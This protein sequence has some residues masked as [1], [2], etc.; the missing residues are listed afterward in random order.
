MTNQV[1]LLYHCRPLCEKFVF[2]R[3]YFVSQF[4]ISQFCLLF[5]LDHRTGRDNKDRGQ[6]RRQRPKPKLLPRSTY[7][8]PTTNQP[9][10]KSWQEERRA[11]D[12]DSRETSA[13]LLE[14][15]LISLHSSHK[16][17]HCC[18]KNSCGEDTPLFFDNNKYY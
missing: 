12:S 14:Y 13:A 9:K 16:E 5:F 4:V 8:H 10:K 6:L 17:H 11:A 15:L 1:N 7:P 3:L 18:N 2:C